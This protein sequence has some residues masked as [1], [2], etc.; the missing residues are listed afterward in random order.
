[1]CLCKREVDE[2]RIEEPFNSELAAKWA[3]LVMIGPHA[4]ASGAATDEYSRLLRRFAAEA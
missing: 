1:M 4:V 3:R 2:G